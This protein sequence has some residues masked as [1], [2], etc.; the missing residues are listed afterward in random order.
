MAFDPNSIPKDLR[1][2]NIA[3]TLPEDSRVAP[4]SSPAAVPVYY[5]VTMAE[6]GFTGLGYGNVAPG[7]PGWC[8][9]IPNSISNALPVVGV[10]NNPNNSAVRMGGSASSQASDEGG[11]DSV[12][13]RKVKFLCS[14]GGKILPR[15]SDGMLRYVGG[16][17]RIISVRS[18]ISFTELVQK[19]A[20]TYGQSVIIK[21]QLPDEDLDALVSVSCPEDLENMM[22]EYEKLIERSSDGSAKLRVFLFRPSELDT[23]GMGNF[24]DFQDGGQ[25]YVEA[26]NGVTDV[27]VTGGIQRKES[28]ASAAS[29]QNSDFSGTEAIDFSN[30]AQGD[31]TG[32]LSTGAAS[33]K[34]NSTTPQDP[35]PRVIP[36]DPRPIDPKP[37]VDTKT[38]LA[39]QLGV[40]VTQ[41]GP[42]AVPPH[43]LEHEVERAA[44]VNAQHPAPYFQTFTDTQQP[45]QMGFP[46]QVM[47]TIGPM[48]THPQFHDNASPVVPTHQYIP[49]V[50]MT[51][52]PPPSHASMRP[53]MV[54]PVMQPQ[55]DQ[56]RPRIIQLPNRQSYHAYPAPV[57]PS[58]VGGAYGCH[59]VPQPEQ[60]VLSE[61]WLPTHQQVIVS[62]EIQ[63]FKGCDKCE[64][65]LPHVHS[66]PAVHSQGAGTAN[67]CV[68][69]ASV[70]HSLRVD[71]KTRAE[72]VNCVAEQQGATRAHQKILGHMDNESAM[73][74]LDLVGTTRID[75]HQFD[76][77]RLNLQKADNSDYPNASF[78]Q[79]VAGLSV[80]GQPP[81]AV[82]MGTR[83]QQFPENALLQQ[84]LPAHYPYNLQKTNNVPVNNDIHMTHESLKDY[85]GNLLASP[86]KDVVV[87]SHD[88]VKE[89]EGKMENLRMCPSELIARNEQI[90]PPVDNAFM[91][92]QTDFDSNYLRAN[93]M[94]SPL[95][96][97][98]FTHTARPVESSEKSK[99]PPLGNPSQYQQPVLGINALAPDEVSYSNY[100]F[101]GVNSAQ[102]AERVQP[103]DWSVDPS[104]L[105]PKL[106]PT[107]VGV[108]ASGGN[109]LASVSPV[110]KVADMQDSSNSLFSNQDPWSLQD[111]SHFPP[112]LPNKIA[113]RKE[114]LGTRAPFDENQFS[115][116][117]ESPKV[118]TAGES[119]CELRLDE[120]DFGSGHTRT[121]QGSA[122]ERI[123]RDLQ[124]VA[125]GVAASVLKSSM[126]SDPDLTKLE[127]KEY[128]PEATPD[129]KV[130]NDIEMHKAKNEE[131]RTKLPEKANLGFSV[132]DGIGRLQIIKNN[133]LEELR[134]LGS[135]TFGTVYHGKW[136]GTDVAIKRINDR[137]FAGK[138]SEV[139][140]MR[141]DFWN[142]AIKLADLHHPNVVAFYGVVLDGP[143]G[144]VATVTEY[145]VNG[146]LR[147]ALQ[148]NERNLDK[149]KRLLIAMDVAFGMEYLH[150]KKI[151]HFDLKSDNLLVNLRD[152]HRPICKV[153]DLGLS[154]VKCHTLISGGV[155]GTLPW[156]APELLNG[157]SS[158]VSEKVD[159]F[160]FGIVMWELITGEEPYS[161]LHY[162]AIIGGIVSNTLRPPVPE[163]CDPDW[164]SL[165]E[166]CWSAE[167]SERPNFTEIANELRGMA[168]KISSKAQNQQ[169]PSSAQ[170]QTKS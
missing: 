71:D 159:V 163:L 64:K 127:R 103:V 122:E 66:D 10:W 35:S 12:P 151:V 123:K 57:P 5:P 60:A 58:V 154:K 78:P 31:V 50:H 132:S 51:L 55:Q 47:G 100:P 126:P 39:A 162:G 82:A 61:G 135:G 48:Y 94:L 160:S 56:F 169:Q 134:E 41:L 24:A 23:P 138:P 92:P 30:A 44:P 45:P 33:P 139:E 76:N 83:P 157:S 25:R 170:P 152:P 19:M 18:N 99:T 150:G 32:P 6:T 75:G 124:G 59:Q 87:E 17:T 16:Q 137:C 141:D 53:N 73:S 7:A 142:E 118:G 130:Q 105:Q 165:M 158:L 72:L 109:L 8:H 14:F 65:S 164:R 3:R 107:N 148:K 52:A 28:I 38:S 131:Q 95:G 34:A 89:I 111:D 113:L 77:D 144:S 156:M 114:G 90:M 15:P 93:E 54:L 86:P 112:P 62:E 20:S 27:V 79:D 43:H 168:A 2:I 68:G 26:V 29:T 106:L 74:Q 42:Q 101:P 161:D 108:A 102:L 98:V 46:S 96:E 166:R 128:V 104:E 63:K 80:G 85:S 69:A 121:T 153:G 84:P 22:D 13:V 147:T 145:M 70:Y 117:G 125:E 37:I 129:N 67:P 36:V 115:N 140:K 40:S 11:D 120:V 9:V 49:P 119:T 110:K 1:P 167:P 133:D 146:S 149:R 88:P 21:Y 155:R 91:K 143:D 4:M 116:F 81:Y 97:V 136:R